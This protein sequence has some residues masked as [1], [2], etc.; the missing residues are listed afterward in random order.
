M[1]TQPLDE[2]LLQAA[3]EGL[4]IQRQRIHDQIA[5][6]QTLLGRRGPGRPPAAETAAAEPA[7]APRKRRKRRTLSAEGRAAIVAALKKR[8]AA[9]KQKAATTRK[10]G[11][12][13]PAKP[14]KKTANKRA[15]KTPAKSSPPPVETEA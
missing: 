2:S 4:E 13:G 11:K 12:S 3:L 5:Q 14:V 1:P 8:W 9:K 7:S 10:V 6:V 15:A